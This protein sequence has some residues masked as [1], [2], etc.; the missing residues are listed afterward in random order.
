M[1]TIIVFECV[2]ASV[3]LAAAWAL[4][5]FVVARP[6]LGRRAVVPVETCSAEPEPHD[7][8]PVELD[9][10]ETDGDGISWPEPTWSGLAIA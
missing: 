5:R 4:L 2:D 3:T 6:A 8:L 10:T 7:E 1:T 9:A